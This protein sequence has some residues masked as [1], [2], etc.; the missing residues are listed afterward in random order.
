MNKLFSSGTRLSQSQREA[1]SRAGYYVYSVRDRED[2]ESVEPFVMVNH[3]EDI[4]TNF[5]V[6]F[7]EENLYMF[8]DFIE[9]YDP[10]FH[11]QDFYD[12]I[13]LI[14]KEAK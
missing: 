1:L 5:K 12:I 14:I 8:D 6:E 10:D 4:V 9:K 3:L 11:N 7:P 2:D 13:R